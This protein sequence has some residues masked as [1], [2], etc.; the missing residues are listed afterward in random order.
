M[1]YKMEYKKFKSPKGEIRLLSPDGHVMLLG[2]E[3]RDVPE[4]LWSDAYSKGALAS[5]MK[6]DSV[7]NH[8]EEKRLELLAQEA[9]E[10]ELIKEKMQVAYQNPALYLDAKNRLIQ[11]K[12]VSLLGKP[13]KRDLMDDIWDEIIIENEKK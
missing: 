11:R 13:I 7:K 2:K 4:F 6:I 1:G 5:D 10:R 3:F 9:K 12:I 8:I